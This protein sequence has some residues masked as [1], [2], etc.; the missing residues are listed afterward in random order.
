MQPG[1]GTENARFWILNNHFQAGVQYIMKTTLLRTAKSLCV[2]AVVWSAVACAHA[3]DG[4]AAAK[5]KTFSG[6]ITAVDA[7]EKVMKAEAYVFHKTFVLADDCKVTLVDQ[8]TATTA[9][10]RPGQKV[11]VSYQNASGVL[12]ASRIAQERLTFQGEVTG[13][14]LDSRTLNVGRRGGGKAFL[15]GDKCGVILNG[16]DKGA[17]ADVK[18]GSRVTVVYEVPDNQFVARQ[19]EQKSARFV[20]TL[21]AINMADRTIKASKQ[22]LGDKRFHLADDCA[23]VINGKMDAKLSDLRL[24]QRYEMSY[25]TVAGVNVVN[26]IAPASMPEKSELSQQN[27]NMQ[28]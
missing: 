7:K 28:E 27:A 12:V 17:L 19:I 5:E 20:G 21:D 14:D 1:A 10:L 16:D 6:T 2:G 22:L 4:N 24:G 25:E 13:I 9:E 15:V 3:D 18:L 26:R 23:I 8:G 11:E